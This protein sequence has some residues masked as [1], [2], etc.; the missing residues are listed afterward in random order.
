MNIPR[1]IPKT[2]PVALIFTLFIGFLLILLSPEDKE[3]GTILKLIYLHSALVTS[4]LS[5]FTAA[6][7]VS[8]VTL[9]RSGMNFKLL[10]AIEKTAVIFWVAATIIGVFI[11]PMLYV[12]IGKI[13][14][15]EKDRERKKKVKEI[16]ESK[17]HE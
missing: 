3:L 12:L 2:V 17:S 11:Y 15:Y 4:G 13:A 5:L 8:M 16:V 10:F 1:K 14:G 7:L 6:G 9:F